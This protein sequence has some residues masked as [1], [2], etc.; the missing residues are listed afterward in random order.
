VCSVWGTFQAL[1]DVE[2]NRFANITLT[3]DI[4][5][6]GIENFEPISWGYPFGGTFDGQGFTISNI[7]ISGVDTSD[8]GLFN[9]VNNATFEDLTLENVTISVP[10][11][12][13]NCGVLAGSAVDTSLT[14]VQ[15]KNANVTCMEEVGGIFGYLEINDGENIEI[16]KVSVDGGAISAHYEDYGSNAGGLFGYVHIYDYANLTIEE[17]YT[18]VSVMA[19][20][21]EAGGLFGNIYNVNDDSDDVADS[22]F[23]LRN[24]YVKGNVTV[25]L[26]DHAGGISG[27]LELEND[28]YDALAKAVFENV[29]VSGDVSGYS[30]VGG[31]IGD[32]FILE[33]DQQIV[34][35]R[36]S[37]FSGTVTGDNADETHA[38]F[39]DDDFIDGG[40]LIMDGV[41]FDQ[42]NSGQTL[43]MYEEDFEGIFAVNTDDSEVNYFIGNDTNP[44]MSE[45]DFDDVWAVDPSGT[46]LLISLN[47]II[48]SEQEEPVVETRTRSRSGG[49]SVKSRVENLE[50]N[51]QTQKAQ[52][53]RQQFP[54][55]F[56]TNTGV[57]TNN[58]LTTVRDLQLGMTGDDVKALQTLLISLN[59]S[60]PAGPTGYFGTQTQN[61]L[62][63]YQKEN[64]IV[65]AIGYFGPLTR[66][67]MKNAGIVG[68]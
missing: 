59:Y 54:N 45:W 47:E 58:N 44:P 67:Q 21:G 55:V 13:G 63:Q 56:G 38:L 31:F 57:T 61:A 8:F 16:S 27:G 11:D 64:S 24:A 15:V 19:Q 35:F 42:T 33:Y 66:A 48:E 41:Y 7:S 49:S 3:Q 32:I 26:E 34:E 53:L 43:A 65:P 30:E 52:E 2:A 39:G 51:G 46:P 40:E 29:Y 25:E 36:N 6:S 14:N 37:F 60:I 18:N 9:A 22:V 10:E 23:T 62:I 20:V 5:C 68:I 12:S 17:V 28:N 50:E 4:D 1:D